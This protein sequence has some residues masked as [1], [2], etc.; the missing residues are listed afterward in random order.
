MSEYERLKAKQRSERGSWHPNLG[1]RVHRALS[2]LQRAE[3]CMDDD[4]RF[5]FLWVSF[6]AAYAQELHQLPHTGQR[7]QFN[8]FLEKLVELDRNRLLYQLIWQEFSNSIRV[9][10]QNR[11][12]FGPFWD[13][14]Q[15]LVGEEDWQSS[16]AN[17]NATANRALGN[18]NTGKV[19]GVVLSRLYVLRNQIVHGG[20]TW[21]SGVNREQV[22]D[23]TAFMLKLVPA[24][25]E[26][27]MD[28]PNTLWGDPAFPV[29]E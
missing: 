4:G 19:L 21:N 2:W 25:I 20:A 23:G 29:V 24:I 15:G 12:V 17:A 3:K 7:Q 26:L 9:L 14:Q 16:F 6:N 27:M 22:R 5:V 1:V 11:Y 8:E 13:Y 28:S 10:L 18:G